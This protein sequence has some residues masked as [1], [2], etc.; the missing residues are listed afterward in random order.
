M[1]ALAA[2]VIAAAAA[3]VAAAVALMRI[4]H[5]AGQ[6]E[7]SN[8]LAKELAVRNALRASLADRDALLAEPHM[9]AAK[10]SADLLHNLA[11]RAVKLDDC[12]QYVALTK[13]DTARRPL[14]RA[15]GSGATTCRC[16]G[17]WPRRAT[18]RAA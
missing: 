12:L 15:A 1:A 8:A 9:R 4:G 3:A 18:A 5:A 11:A 7:L 16:T 6:A 10:R 17:R 2:A 14:A 13:I